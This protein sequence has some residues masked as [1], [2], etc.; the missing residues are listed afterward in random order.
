MLVC[1]SRSPFEDAPKDRQVQAVVVAILHCQL[2]A[3]D[4]W[5]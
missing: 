2:F 5:A 3:I 4:L 1:L